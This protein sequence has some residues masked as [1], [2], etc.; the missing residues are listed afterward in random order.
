LVPFVFHGDAVS[1]SVR[2]NV[3]DVNR[4][5]AKVVYINTLFAK[6]GTYD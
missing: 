1:E 5:S 4:F 2:D 3:V 6:S